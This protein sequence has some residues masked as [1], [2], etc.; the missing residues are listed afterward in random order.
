MS[1]QYWGFAPARDQRTLYPPCN[2]LAGSRP[3]DHLI[4]GHLATAKPAREVRFVEATH[5]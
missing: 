3:G 2:G 5:W 1:P 4:K